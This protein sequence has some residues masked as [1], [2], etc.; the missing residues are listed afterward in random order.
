MF[1]YLFSLSL[2][3]SYSKIHREGNNCSIVSRSGY[4]WIFSKAHDQES[5]NHSAHFAEW[6]SSYITRSFISSCT[7]I[8]QLIF[9]IFTNKQWLFPWLVQSELIIRAEKNWVARYLWNTCDI[10]AS[11]SL[12]CATN[13]KPINVGLRKRYWVRAKRT[14]RAWICWVAWAIISW[15]A[16][17][18]CPEAPKWITKSKRGIS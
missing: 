2:K 12:C 18:T 16:K 9:Q 17:K 5:T 6:K 11:E 4:I 15:I 14:I 13:F 10:L 8:V 7:C 3:Q 1:C